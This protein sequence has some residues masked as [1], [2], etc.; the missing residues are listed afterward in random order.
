M[1]D[2]TIIATATIT[3]KSENQDCFGEFEGKGF[4]AIFV[5]DG[6][7]SFAYPKLASEKVVEYFLKSSEELN[8]SEQVKNYRIDF[9]AVFKKAKEYLIEFAKECLKDKEPKDGDLFGTTLIAVFETDKKITIAYVGNGAIWHIR[10][11]FNSFPSPYLFPW[12]AI[13]LLNPHSIPQ[14]GKEALYK[15]FTDNNDFDE[16]I[17]TV[18]E[19]SKDEQYGD[20][21]M[22]CSD[23]I[24]SADQLKAGI[25]NKGFVRVKYEPTMLDF[26]KKLNE[27]F[28]K[29]NCNKELLKEDLDQYLQQI[30]P[31][32][33]DDATIGVL[34]TKE[35]LNYQRKQLSQNEVNQDNQV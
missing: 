3:N 5:A 18:I 1:N 7:G 9:N 12:N 8:N 34:I 32:L 2:K 26:Y 17:P 25:D 11:S 14:N 33:D 10:A 16:C 28:Q 4:N 15:L 27:Y 35:V 21:I 31:L 13:N 19:I 29:E 30:K 20:I 24:S 22:I 6:L 23:G